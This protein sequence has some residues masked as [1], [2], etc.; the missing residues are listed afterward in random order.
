MHMLDLCQ[1]VSSLIVFPTTRG[2]GE[3]ALSD[4]LNMLTKKMRAVVEG[5]GSPSLYLDSG[6][7]NGAHWPEVKVHIERSV[8]IIR[9]VADL[10]D[11]GEV[12][13]NLDSFFGLM[14]V[15]VLRAENLPN[16]DASLLFPNRG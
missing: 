15:R 12:E 11:V 4:T 3:E 7:T 1:A 13:R 14:V 2:H 5:M 9:E 6:F 10:G 16:T 8:G